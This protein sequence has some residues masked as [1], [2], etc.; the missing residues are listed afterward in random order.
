MNLEFRFA[1]PDEYPEI[2]SFVNDH[3]AKQH[4]YVRSEPLFR[5]TFARESIWHRDGFSVAVALLDGELAGVLGGIPFTFNHFGN[6]CQGVW[7]ANYVIRESARKGPAALKLLSMLRGDPFGATLA[8]GINPATA[9]I[10]R[11]LKGQVFPHIPRH[12]AVFP[13]AAPRM[14]A[15]LR[16][17]HPDWTNGEADC[18]SERHVFTGRLNEAAEAGN[19]ISDDWDLVNWAEIAPTVIGAARDREYL[20]WRYVRHPQ[21]RY[22]FVTLREG[23]R[24]GLAV[25][26]LETIHQAMPEGGRQ[27]VDRIARIVEFLPASDE[28]ASALLSSMFKSIRDEG[29]VGADYYGFHG[30]TRGLLNRLGFKEA[31][32]SA[33]DQIPGRFQPLDGKGGNIL[34]AGFLPAGVQAC[35]L[36]INC[37]WYWTKSDS[38]QDRPN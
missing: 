18:L 26:R 1:N 4:I 13:E 33:A 25:W 32:E 21:F 17:S 16:I 38:D 10:Y 2:A 35:S 37:P 14:T 22:R 5:W 36:D 7:L 15:L 6:S 12:V 11:V 3:W 30:K 31:E 23:L 34:S 27:P 19:S 20:E 28:N 24:T 8:F 9:N 29:A